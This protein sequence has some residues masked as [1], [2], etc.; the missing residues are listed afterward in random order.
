MNFRRLMPLSFLLVFATGCGG[1]TTGTSTTTS[2]GTTSGGTTTGAPVGTTTGASTGGTTTGTTTGTVGTSTGTH[3]IP[4]SKPLSDLTDSELEELCQANFTARWTD[5]VCLHS[6][7]YLA[8]Q[9]EE[10]DDR[11]FTDICT[12]TYTG[13]V[14]DDVYDPNTMCT[15]VTSA[16]ILPDCIY[17]VAEYEACIDALLLTYDF[18]GDCSTPD[19]APLEPAENPTICEQV[20][21]CFP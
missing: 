16:D 1:S 3:S 4:A 20:D 18:G 9:I 17:T 6:S 15:Q 7:A 5:Q 19:L 10:F 14:E 11:S 21:T 12:E 13:C 8:N 2:G